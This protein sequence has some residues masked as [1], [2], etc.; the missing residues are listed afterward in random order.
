MYAQELFGVSIDVTGVGRSSKQQ[1]QYLWLRQSTM[2]LNCW[3]HTNAKEQS[4][5]M[6]PVLKVSSS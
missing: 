5:R 1:Q 3:T 2:P 6:L 4:Y